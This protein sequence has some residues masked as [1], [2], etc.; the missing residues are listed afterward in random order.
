MDN[1][2]KTQINFTKGISSD[3]LDLINCSDIVAMKRC[4]IRQCL[5]LYLNDYQFSLQ[6][7]LAN[8][9]PI[10]LK[11]VGEDK[12]KN[13]MKQFIKKSPSTFYN[14]N[15]YHPDFL[16]FFLHQNHE[17]AEIIKTLSTL[18]FLIYQLIDESDGIEVAEQQ[19]EV[20]SSTTITFHKSFF[21]LEANFDLA[22]LWI[23]ENL[24]DISEL[25]TRV[26]L[27]SKVDGEIRIKSLTTNQSKLLTKLKK[28]DALG[29]CFKEIKN[30]KA[31]EV[32]LFFKIITHDKL[33][34]KI[35]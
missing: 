13:I 3:H 14:V 2:L 20:S 25:N 21:T 19:K 4:S 5:T 1:L 28:G 31:E 27:I 32:D 6:E 11:I 33:I 15:E 17:R 7:V 30:L 8:T 10:T 22:S 35:I 34:K 9:Y 12:F 16:G 26:F 24:E 18:E 29:S 23:N